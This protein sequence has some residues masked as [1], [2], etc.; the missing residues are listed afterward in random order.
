MVKKGTTHSQYGELEGVLHEKK[1]QE[2]RLGGPKAAKTGLLCKW[3]VKA[4]EPCKSLQLMLRYILARFN[5][6]RGRKWGVS[7]DRFTS[8]HHQGFTG[9]KYG[10]TLVK[11]RSQW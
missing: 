6:K 5:P 11:P 1:V 10:V 7:L 3:I 2:P 8:K 4:M 9:Q